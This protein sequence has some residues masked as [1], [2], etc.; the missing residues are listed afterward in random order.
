[1]TMYLHMGPL[2]ERDSVEKRCIVCNRKFEGS[3]LEPDVC[4]DCTIEYEH[5]LDDTD[6]QPFDECEGELNLGRS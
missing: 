2:D 4:S 5:F 1:M 3:E 6:G